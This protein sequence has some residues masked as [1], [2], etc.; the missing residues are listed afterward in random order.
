MI[1][2]CTLLRME[3]ER[4]REME[5]ACV[6]ACVMVSQ[7]RDRENGGVTRSR[8]RAAW[9]NPTCLEQEAGPEAARGPCQPHLVRDLCLA[10]TQ[11]LWLHGFGPSSH[12]PRSREFRRTKS[13][14]KMLAN[15]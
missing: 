5:M 12:S 6:K 14:S 10:L 9:S 7:V 13:I 15:G 1:T 4:E 8:G 2:D 3:R 11:T